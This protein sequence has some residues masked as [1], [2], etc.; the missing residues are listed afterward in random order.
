MCMYIEEACVY[1][2]DA[3]K[4]WLWQEV[5]VTYCDDIQD[6]EEAVDTVPWV[7]L[8]HHT[9][10]AIL[11]DMTKKLTLMYTSSNLCL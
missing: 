10:F 7:N 5:G 6:A 4:M 8:L 11:E 3:A 2:C 1:V 9:F